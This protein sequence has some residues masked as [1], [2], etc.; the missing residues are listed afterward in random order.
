[1]GRDATSL[2]RDRMIN[3]SKTAIVC[4]KIQHTRINV[5][6]ALTHQLTLMG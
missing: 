4:S 1:M 3:E 5:L 2:L 6:T